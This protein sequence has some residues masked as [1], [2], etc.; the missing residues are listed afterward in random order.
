MEMRKLE[1]KLASLTRYAKTIGFE[2]ESVDIEP[3]FDVTETET[4]Q[5]RLSGPI[6]HIYLE[7]RLAESKQG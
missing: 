3:R 1:Q 4:G 2:V 5:I 6:V 7:L